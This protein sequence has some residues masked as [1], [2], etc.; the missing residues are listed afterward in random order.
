[1][2]ISSTDVAVEASKQNRPVVA[3]SNNKEVNRDGGISVT[4]PTTQGKI[5]YTIE[6]TII[7]DYTAWPLFINV[8]SELN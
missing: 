5:V 3:L 4:P 7:A 6:G 2:F 1:M 8:A